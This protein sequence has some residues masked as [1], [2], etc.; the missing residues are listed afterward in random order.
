[1]LRSCGSLYC[2]IRQMEVNL[3]SSGRGLLMFEYDFVSGTPNISTTSGLCSSF[4]LDRVI[5]LW[6]AT[7]TH[8]LH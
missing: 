1:M 8:L 3:G 7:G 6:G 5:E 2:G 4:S